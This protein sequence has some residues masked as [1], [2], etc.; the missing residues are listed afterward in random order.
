MPK[1][2]I[3][4]CPMD[5]EIFKVPD[6]VDRIRCGECIKECPVGALSFEYGIS[7]GFKGLS[8]KNYK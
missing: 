7:S 6:S 4:I 1:V 8:G 3:I 2:R 5:V